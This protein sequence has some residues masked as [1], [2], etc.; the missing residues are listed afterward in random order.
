MT[1]L[2]TFV[3]EV[4][5]RFACRRPGAGTFME[6]VGPAIEKAELNG[7]NLAASAFD[8]RRLHL[9]GLEAQNVLTVKAVAAYSHDGIGMD[10]FTDPVDGLDYLHTQCA[11]YL[12]HR[13]FA[14]FDQPD[15]K[16]TFSFEVKAPE[17]WVVVSNMPGASADG[18]WT[19]DKTPVLSTYLTGI[20]A[21]HYHS[22]HHDHGD[23]PLG[24]Y[25]RQSLASHLDPDE[26]FD[27]TGRG[28]DYFGERFRFRYP[29]GKYDQ[30][31]VPEFS[32]GAMENPGCVMF[33]EHYL[34]R[35]RVT[36]ERRMARAETIL[37]E[38]AHMWFGDLVT[39]RWWDDIWL[40]ETFAEYVGYLGV[41]TAT[42][43]TNVWVDFANGTKAGAKAQD[44]LPTTHPIVADIPDT[45][46]LH[47]NF[48]NITYNKGAAVLKQLV[49][50]VGE[51]AFFTGIQGYFQRH[52]YG[53]TDLAD[54]LN[55]LEEASGRDLS[56]WSKVWLEQA[57][58]NTLRAEIASDDGRITSASIV[59]LAPELHP[60]LRPHRLRVGM[61]DRDGSAL[62]RRTA[63]EL[64]V[65]GPRTPVPQLIGKQVPDLLLVNDG[66]LTYAKLELDAR[67]LAT[68]KSHLKGLD[69]PLAR[70]V[71]WGALWDMARDAQL[72]AREYVATALDNID[73][74]TDAAALV[75]LLARIASALE[76]LAGTAH[77]AALRES[78]ASAARNRM[79]QMLPGSDLQLLWVQ[80]F[81]SAARKP[82]D[83][84]WV[85]GLLDGTNR[86]D[87]LAVDLA[88]RWAAVTALAG[89]GVVGA[90]RIAAELRRDPTYSGRRSA[91]TAR[92]ARPLPEA[93]AEAWTAVRGDSE[94]LTMKRAYAMGFHGS[95]QE[96]ILA[97]YVEPYFESLL[98]VWE[99]QNTEEALEF[100]DAMYPRLIITQEVV[101]LAD[102][103]IRRDL[104]GPIRRSLLESQDGTKR[105][106][107]ARTYDGS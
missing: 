52:A 100:I 102:S 40:N 51:E 17:D 86:L 79:P 34:F 21:G 11:E 42:R 5:V 12:A 25:C 64:D 101:D 54:F 15:L 76:V 95:D 22:V 36:D 27:I 71:A 107:R 35:S 7:K 38:M 72:S 68:L 73:A 9:E 50:W 29:F 78:L 28:L 94:S 19:F 37:H 1:G 106:L 49:A 41:A 43:F 98:P 66:D 93:K 88:V 69:D 80:T 84:A 91:A 74:E 32:A 45:E 10:R 24:I 99:S 58:V 90:E 20:V 85:A 75:T 83:V 16:A 55:A 56:S 30:L 63:V 53:N 59:Q 81:I 4:S 33:R 48:D 18:A 70:A 82:E 6:F 60:T 96:A 23:I 13:V 89:I 92:A 77:R 65:D 57:G 8:G 2:E 3:S 46:S 62:T 104:P 26:I 67:S 103:W 14:C 47:L 105:A 44:Q 87:G 31:F 39:M 97:T 61:F